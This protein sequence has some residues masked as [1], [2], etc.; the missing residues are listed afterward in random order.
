MK[1][2]ALLLACGILSATDTTRVYYI[3]RAVSGTANKITIRQPSSGARPLRFES[4]WV[5]CEGVA[6]TV[7]ISKNGTLSGGSAGTIL[8]WD[9]RGSAAKATATLDGTVASDT[10]VVVESLSSN[11][12]RAFGGSDLPMYLAASDSPKQITLDL[13][14][15][16]S[17]TLRSLLVFSEP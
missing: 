17:G 11:E 9:D 5:K 4:A 6:C 8:A 2:L 12:S 1:K 13:T 10:A 7:T 16:S 3:Y 15:G 14:A